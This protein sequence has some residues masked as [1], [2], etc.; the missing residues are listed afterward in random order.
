L[1][2]AIPP[3][4]RFPRQVDVD[5]CLFCFDTYAKAASGTSKDRLTTVRAFVAAGGS[6][7]VAYGK[8]TG[9]ERAALRS[10]EAAMKRL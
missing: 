3:K 6:A 9:L 5:A 2:I 1:D 7:R 4:L 10:G 8:K